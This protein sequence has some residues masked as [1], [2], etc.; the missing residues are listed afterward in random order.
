VKILVIRNKP[1]WP[2][3]YGGRLHCYELCR[4]LTERHQ[5]LLVA[6][7]PCEADD[8]P[9]NFECRTARNRRLFDD[10]A[11][12][13]VEGFRSHRLDRFFGI[14]PAFTRD[15]VKLTHKWQPDVV[16]GMNYR[17][18][19]HLAHI[20]EVPTVCDLLD[21]EVLHR[22]RELLYSRVQHTWVD[23]KTLVATL[24]YQ[25]R[26]LRKVSA[27]TV[28][29]EA[30]RRF[31]RLYTGHP[32]IRYIP[33][34]VDCDHYAPTDVEVDENRIVFCGAL[35]FGPNVSAVLFF[36]DRVWPLIRRARPKTRW[37]ILGWGDGAE[38][39]RIKALPGVDFVGR[40]D[41]IRPHVARA[42]VAI[43][44]MVSGTG[45]KNK[46]MEAWAMRKPVLCT[47]KAL[48]S[49]P[50]V[51]QENVWLARSPKT[52]A[53]GVVQLLGSRRL[54]ERI[55]RSARQTAMCHCSWDRA[56]DQLERLCTELTTARAR[57]G[58]D[59]D[60]VRVGPMVC[61]TA[62]VRFG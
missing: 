3:C 5:V 51:H 50:G 21:D 45:I 37:S 25:R 40:V 43:V 62:D 53:D 11:D 34:G 10:R 29:S 4:R 8:L 60:D 12:P 16:I 26:Y 35:G 30:D 47:P 19:A 6:E 41:D 32:Q 48:G 61:P 39:Q 44:P 56:A 1:P 18:L 17:S 55:G 36:A 54:R 52:L 23:L 38:L 57:S 9:F 2:L 13:A 15:V 20:T 49:L 22:L 46:I 28:L 7:Q 14:S 33:H 42:A 58:R 59:A 31:C 24:L 27:I